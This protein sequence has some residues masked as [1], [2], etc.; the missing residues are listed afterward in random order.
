MDKVEA[1]D[2]YKDKTMNEKAK[3]KINILRPQKLV[4]FQVSNDEALVK[5]KHTAQ[6][7]DIYKKFNNGQ[8][9]RGGKLLLD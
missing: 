4:I 1:N 3:Q 8:F 5:T 6:S 2:N 7:L 9:C